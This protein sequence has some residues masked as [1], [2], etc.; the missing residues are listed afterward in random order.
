M[1]TTSKAPA[2]RVSSRHHGDLINIIISSDVRGTLE[3]QH[4]PPPGILYINSSLPGRVPRREVFVQQVLAFL[5]HLGRRGV[6]LVLAGTLI[7]VSLSP[8]QTSMATSS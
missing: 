5:R 2:L 1:S 7:W 3:L 8:I 6:M 4:V